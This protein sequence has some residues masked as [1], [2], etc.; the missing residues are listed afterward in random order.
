MGLSGAAGRLVVAPA[1][2]RGFF[3]LYG[4]DKVTVALLF[5]HRNQLKLDDATRLLIEEYQRA[6]HGVSE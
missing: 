5:N 2:N 3:P 6:S 1:A 4:R